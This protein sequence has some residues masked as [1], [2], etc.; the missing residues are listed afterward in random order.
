MLATTRAPQRLEGLGVEIVDHA[1]LPQRLESGTLVLHS[2]PPAGSEGLIELLGDRPSRVVYLSSTAVYGSAKNVD[3]TTLVDPVSP[4]ARARFNCEQQVQTGP[5]SSLILRPAAIYGPGRG[6]HERVRRGEFNLDEG[7]VSRIHAEDLATH[8]EA[9]L[10]SDVTGAWPVA[11][12]EPCSAREITK[13]CADL[14]GIPVPRQGTPVARRVA[15]RRVDGSAIRREL[16]ITLR[17]PSFRAGIP[18]ALDALAQE[19]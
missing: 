12:G 4:D 13:F 9:T 11:D 6:A 15:N 19:P 17:Y 18:A 7:L 1:D 16:G 10:F 14:L 8:I 5:W 2:I 3:E